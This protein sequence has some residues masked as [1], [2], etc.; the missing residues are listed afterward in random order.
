MQSELDRLI[1]EATKAKQ[2]R[3]RLEQ[4]VE[5]EQRAKKA[6]DD[7]ARA[8]KQELDK[9][10]KVAEADS[11][12]TSKSEAELRSQSQRISE[13]TASLAESEKR[14]AKKAAEPSAEDIL[15]ELGE[16]EAK[17]RDQAREVTRL[18]EDLHKT[19]RFGR[20]LIAELNQLKA[21][22]QATSVAHDLAR[23]AEQNAQ[24]A[25]DLEAARWTISS[26]EAN[27]GGEPTNVLTSLA[28]ARRDDALRGEPLSPPKPD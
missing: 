17:L 6:L 13:L 2:E 4:L 22:R 27:V 5:T 12:R 19:E 20:Q 28:A 11:R 25:A 24:L 9:L 8:V 1:A 23:L 15:P 10:L 18:T 7:N 16:L 26:L 14:H 3:T 21:E